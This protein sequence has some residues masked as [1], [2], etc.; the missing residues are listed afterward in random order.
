VKSWAIPFLRNLAALLILGLLVLWLLPA[1]LSYAGEQARKHPWRTLLTGLLVFVVGWFVA[2]LA[3]LLILALAIFFY[4]VSLPNLGFLIGT[5]GLSSIGIAISIFWL[6]IVFF[7][8]IVVAF[9]CGSLFF[10]RFLPKYA[11]RRIWPFLLGVIVYALLASIPYLGW[12]VAVI[13]TF[14]GLGAIWKLTAMR[15]QSEA[16]EGNQA[17]EAEQVQISEEIQPTQDMPETSA[18][19][20]V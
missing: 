10:K 17:Q 18:T 6:D 1:Q 14:L 8:K 12:L 7:S 5:L 2:L 16:P 13:V 9:L 3:T 11:H 4:W 19:T 20:E 15:K